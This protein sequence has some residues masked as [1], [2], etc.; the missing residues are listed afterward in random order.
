VAHEK[1]DVRHDE[2]EDHFDDRQYDLDEGADHILDRD[3]DY[4][5]FINNDAD[6]LEAAILEA[7]AEVNDLDE[8]QHQNVE[9]EPPRPQTSPYQQVLQF[10][11]PF[12]QI[13]CDHRWIYSPGG[14][15]CSLYHW[16]ADRFT[17][18]YSTCAAQVC[19]SCSY[20]YL[21]NLEYNA[22][23]GSGMTIDLLDR[24]AEIEYSERRP[25][26]PL[27]GG[28]YEDVGYDIDRLHERFEAGFN[29]SHPFLYEDFGTEA[30]YGRADE[31][32]NADNPRAVIFQTDRGFEIVHGDPTVFE[33][34]DLDVEC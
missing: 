6:V 29:E 31:T 21:G 8:A 15:S 33:Y 20:D 25:F 32:Y 1:E 16:Y 34:L 13:N 2:D 19:R 10:V 12:S 22:P 11:P 7:E 27:R 9:P 28:H 5:G 18:N 23:G 3:G 14:G 24:R 17:N 26:E 4:D 30:L